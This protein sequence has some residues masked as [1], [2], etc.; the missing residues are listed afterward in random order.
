M[1]LEKTIAQAVSLS[2]A[3]YIEVRVEENATTR[4]HFVGEQLE[5]ISESSELGGCVRACKNGGWGFSSFCDLSQLPRQAQEAVDMANQVGKSST[6]LKPVA[7]IQQQSNGSPPDNP[8]DI[9]LDEKFQLCNRYNNI[10]NA[11]RKIQ[12]SIVRYE[13]RLQKKHFANSEGT[14]TYQEGVFCGLQLGAIACEGSIVQTASRGFGDLKGYST[15]LNKES[16]AEDVVRRATDMLSAPRV[17]SGVYTVIIDPLLCGVF[18]HEAFGHLS[19]A[20]HIYENE[21]LRDILQ[22]GRKFGPPQL[23]VVDDATLA[24]EAGYYPFDDEGVPAKKNY[25]ICAGILSGRLHNRETAAKMN[26]EPTGSARA[27]SFE[28]PPIIRMGNTL[29]EAGPHSFEQ[30]VAETPDGLY[31]KG[32]LGGQTNCEM[33]TFS[34]AEAFEIKDGKIGGRVRDVVLS[35]NVF[36]TLKNMDR[37]GNDVQMFGS[38]G[39]CGK[40]NQSPLRVG[41]GGPHIRIQKVVIGGN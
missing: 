7:P 3:D 15:V 31:V 26:E 33:F 23:N 14:H 30:M 21:R 32:A 40:H 12:T 11:G 5:Q 6:H 2:G 27:I 39:G 13:D 38:L 19:E 20:D 4:I 1:N 41:L 28:Y 34:A 35:G 37:I 22:I 18:I 29:V 10:L 24:G 8:L 36:E 16:E 9:S 17:K 25:L